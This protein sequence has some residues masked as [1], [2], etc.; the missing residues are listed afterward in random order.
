[1]D[2]DTFNAL[3]LVYRSH[4][5]GSATSLVAELQDGS[6]SFADQRLSLGKPGRRSRASRSDVL[7]VSISLACF[8]FGVAAVA[9][10][11][12][13]VWLG[14]TNQLVV[15]GF[16]LSIMSLLTF[17]Q[18][19]T[20][21]LMIEARFGQSTLQNYDGMLFHPSPSDCVSALQNSQKTT[22]IGLK[23]H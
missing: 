2:N 15:L 9:D 6:R 8:A 5:E 3:P 1:M 20:L 16:A 19:Q 12:L 13:A 10:T 7:S 22:A 21:M 17:K 4:T 23:Y 11:G 14:Q 18:A